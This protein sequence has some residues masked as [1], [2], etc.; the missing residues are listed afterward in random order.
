[1]KKKN[2]V[3]DEGIKTLKSVCIRRGNYNLMTGDSK[4]II[5][6]RKEERY[7]IKPIKDKFKDRNSSS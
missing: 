2:W 7:E 4:T 5:K 3:R 1:M 6:S